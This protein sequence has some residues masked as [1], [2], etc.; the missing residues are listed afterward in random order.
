MADPTLML[1]VI[2]L[3]LKINSDRVKAIGD[4]QYVPSEQEHTR[5]DI[6]KGVLAL[7][8]ILAEGSSAYGVDTTHP[9][10][11]VRRVDPTAEDAVK[12]VVQ[13]AGEA[14]GL[15]RSSWTSTFSRS[16]DP[17]AAYRD[18]V[19]GVESVACML[20]IP[21]DPEPTLGKAIGHLASTAAKWSVAGLDDKKQASG[22]TLLSMLRTVWQN[23]ER[24]VA[25]GGRAP[26]G[27]TQEEA[28]AV[29]F[30]AVTLVQ[31]FERGLVKRND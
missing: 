6:I 23:H 10:H 22:E 4:S 14:S 3:V 28:E 26:E 27:A 2:E 7:M 29:V 18:A 11:L 17:D 5:G 19:F 12:D 15:I 16:P 1:D 13:R 9:W 20:F 8:E 30:L 21:N 24:H 31:W 25:Q